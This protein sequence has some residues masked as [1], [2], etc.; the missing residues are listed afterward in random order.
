MLKVEHASVWYGVTPVLHDVSFEVPDKQVIALLGGN[1]A[2]KSTTLNMLSGLLK[3]RS[4]TVTLGG[5]RVDGLHPHDIVVHGMAQVP[6]GRYMWPTMSVRDNI[7]LGAI[8]RHDKTAIRDDTAA[9]L[10]MFPVLAERGS[11]RAGDLSG[12]QQQ[13]LAIA[14]ALM[15][16]PSILL[17]DEP[18]HGLSPKLV[19]EMVA[20]IRRLN[21][22][23]LA[24]LLVEQNVGVAAALASVAHVLRN[25]NIALTTTGAELIGNAEL[26][27]SYL[28]R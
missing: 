21:E 1:G 25:G 14:R 6:Q 2:G 11:A 13:M 4:G 26:L 7:A 9:V 12:G 8:T 27:H 23:G 15:S 18:S 16:R 10:D 20:I 3:P 17:M 28:G 24:I 19:E 22:S 5:T